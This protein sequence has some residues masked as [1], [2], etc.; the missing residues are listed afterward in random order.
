[1]YSGPIRWRV[2]C[3]PESVHI[4]EG[5]WPSDYTATQCVPLNDL[6]SITSEF[7][8]PT[9]LLKEFKNHKKTITSC[10]VTGV[11]VIEASTLEKADPNCLTLTGNNWSENCR[12]LTASNWSVFTDVSI[13]D[14]DNLVAVPSN[15][16]YVKSRS[17][18]VV[19]ET[20][21]GSKNIMATEYT[22]KIGC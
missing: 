1:M 15:K 10:P 2:I 21:G 22:L 4:E 9:F 11:L 8:M 18:H 14:L 19:I 7:K 13:S 17:F 12:T 5:V 16:G 6:H 20:Q 3:G